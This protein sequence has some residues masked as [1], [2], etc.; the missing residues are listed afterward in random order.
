MYKNEQKVQFT[1]IH[2]QGI[3]V[4]LK[5]QLTCKTNFTNWP[6]KGGSWSKQLISTSPL[7]STQ[8]NHALKTQF[9]KIKQNYIAKQNI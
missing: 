8:N 2:V 9:V 3:N 4:H 5:E 7:Y 6:E 1:V